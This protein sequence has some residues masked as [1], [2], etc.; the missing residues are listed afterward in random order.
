[1][2]SCPG[3]D[4]IHEAGDLGLEALEDIEPCGE[5]RAGEEGAQGVV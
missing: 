3:E 4:P 2:T 5:K 1:M